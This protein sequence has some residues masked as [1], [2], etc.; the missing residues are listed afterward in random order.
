MFCKLFRAFVFLHTTTIIYASQLKEI[1]QLHSAVEKRDIVA[2]QT[3]FRDF[4]A[5]WKACNDPTML[6]QI[7]NNVE[8]YQLCADALNSETWIKYIG[9][10]TGEYKKLTKLEQEQINMHGMMFAVLAVGY[11][12][13]NPIAIKFSEKLKKESKNSDKFQM[14]LSL[15]N[16]TLNNFQHEKFAVEAPK[17][18]ETQNI[19]PYFISLLKEEKYLNDVKSQYILTL[20]SSEPELLTKNSSFKQNKERIAN[21]IEQKFMHLPKD[22]ENIHDAQWRGQQA[23]ILLHQHCSS[24]Q[25]HRQWIQKIAGVGILS[26]K[27]KEKLCRGDN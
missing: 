15:W 4:F 21:L 7:S 17:I 1:Q 14:L 11:L 20:I 27:L 18:T 22:P 12:E 24:P 23:F 19:L 26:S 8:L 5:F 13:K 2:V 9:L 25:R 6:R 3:K 16:E 10:S